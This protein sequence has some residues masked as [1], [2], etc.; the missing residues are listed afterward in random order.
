METSTHADD[1]KTIRKIMEESSRFLSLSGLSGVFAGIFAIIGFIIALLIL[2][3]DRISDAGNIDLALFIDA[4]VI[5]IAALSVSVFLSYRKAL[6]NGN[7]IW[8]GITKR[9]LLNL[10]IP[11]LSAAAFILIFYIEQNFRYIIPSMLV[12]YGLA[13]VNVGKFTFGEIQ[14]LG[15]LQV[16]IGIISAVFTEYALYLWVLG[17][18]ILHILYGLIMHKKY[19]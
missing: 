15:I 17:F 2:N 6:R 4:L 7:R 3:S 11:L 5:L 10:I 16:L 8:T 19:R 9:M 18:G 12:F 14:Y 13:L 1:L